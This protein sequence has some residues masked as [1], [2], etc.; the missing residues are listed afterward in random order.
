MGTIWLS[1]HMGLDIPVAVKILKSSLIQEAPEYIERFIQE[2]NVAGTIHHKNIIRIFD[3]GNQGNIYYMVMEYVDGGNAQEMIEERGR[4][5][6]DEVLEF[7]IVISD[8]LL[9]AHTNNVIHR[10]IKPENIMITREGR[11][12]IADLGLAKQLGDSYSS[13]MIGASIGTPNYISPEQ[14]KNS[15]SADHRCDIYSLGATL[16]HMLTGKVPFEGESNYEVMRKHCEQELIPPQEIHQGLP[17]PLCKA[18]CKMM[19]KK[20]DDRFQSCEEINQ[21]LNKYK[22]SSEHNHVTTGKT[23]IMLEKIDVDE[24]KKK[25]KEAK[26]RREKEQ[27]A[28]KK[29]LT[30]IISC[31]IALMIIMTAILNI[32]GNEKVKNAGDIPTDRA[33]Q[34]SQES[35]GNFREDIQGLND[36]VKSETAN[37]VKVNTSEI[38]NV[39]DFTPLNYQLE[40]KGDAQNCIDLTPNGLIINKADRQNSIFTGTTAKYKNFKLQIVYRWL[41]HKGSIKVCLYRNESQSIDLTLRK[42]IAPRSGSLYFKNHDHID[43]SGLYNEDMRGDNKILSHDLIVEKETNEW[44]TVFV[45][46]KMN[47]IKVYVNENEIGT[48]EAE[49]GKSVIGLNLWREAN[50]EFKAFEI[51]EIK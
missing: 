18:I 4:L 39:K 24:L 19:A 40:L 51:Q 21:I 35:E 20:P 38:R 28:K 1:H 23:Q 43:Y 29:K 30:Y 31:I 5:T 45:L 7:G 47:T 26:E 17:T 11:I 3:A 48:V 10:D 32:S 46:K 34:N 37:E 36:T 8:A 16:Y 41:K 6:P 50:I 42:N 15:Q 12:K 14:V 44:N 2:G 49:M 33:L 9:E 13:T 27:A 25:R 22:Y